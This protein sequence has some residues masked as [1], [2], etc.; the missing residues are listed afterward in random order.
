MRGHHEKKVFLNTKLSYI[1]L[2]NLVSS[3]FNF[4]KPVKL[5]NL[6][7]LGNKY[8][9]GYILPEHFVN[10]SDGLISFGYGYDPSF[11]NEYIKKSNNKVLIYDHTCNYLTLIKIFLK[12]LKRF[13][14]FKKQ[15]KDVV[16]H[17]N[18]LKRHHDFVRSKKVNFFKKK[19]VKK[20]L[21]HNEINIDK[22]IKL[23]NFQ[24]II[25]KCDIEG[26][27]YEIIDDMLKYENLINCIVIEFH[28]ID[29]NLTTFKLMVKKL[30]NFYQ[31]VHLH[32]NNHDPI[33]K[34]LNIPSTLEITFVKKIFIKK[35]EFIKKFPVDGLDQ[36][37]NPF[38]PDHVIYFE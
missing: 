17:Y 25:L 14:L 19:I 2:M 16:Y 34:D 20:E 5:Y 32:G 30:L 26:S 28:H 3:E 11:E 36:P 33:I 21:N 37:N 15:F 8:D 38:I 9:G 27:E 31:I 13:L 18:N 29:L 35:E 1:K 4:L 10:N 23:S 6:I 7:R 24:N 22:I 12:Y